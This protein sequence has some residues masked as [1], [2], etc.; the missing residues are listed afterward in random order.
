MLEG[1]R[2]LGFLDETVLSVL[3]GDEIR[4][5]DFHRYFALQ[6]EV[7][8]AIDD[9][10]PATADFTEDLVVRERSSDQKESL[11]ERGTTRF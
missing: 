8:G 3:V 1:G 11:S 7:E 10:H 9:S 4:G 2:G 6:T 5:K